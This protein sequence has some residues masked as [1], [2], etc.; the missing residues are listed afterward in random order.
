T[1]LHL[2]KQI[3]PNGKAVLVS[4]AAG[5]VG[6]LLVQL[7]KRAGA[8]TVVAAASTAKK[9]DFARSL[10]ADSGVDYTRSD[11]VELARAACGGD[12]PDIIYESV[13]GGV[14]KACL[15]MLAPLGEL[16]IY[17]A[18]NIQGFQ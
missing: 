16:V 6:T 14:T 9:L 7:D 11:W 1:A 5:G 15:Q 2:T 17:G 8:R 18:L 3:P 10:G 12:G 13:G 4:A